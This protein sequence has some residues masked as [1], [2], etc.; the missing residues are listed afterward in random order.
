MN[1]LYRDANFIEKVSKNLIKNYELF[2][3]R[4]YKNEDINSI[5]DIVQFLE[6]EVIYLDIKE[7]YN[8]NKMIYLKENDKFVIIIDK[9]FK[10]NKMIAEEKE[11]IL[12]MMWKYLQSR[13]HFNLYANT[14]IYPENSNIDE[15]VIRELLDKNVKKYIKK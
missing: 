3:G 14:L 9:S 10:N 1:L 8:I 15:N 2:S 11:I 6:G 7:K 4:K 13:I 5:K 12:D